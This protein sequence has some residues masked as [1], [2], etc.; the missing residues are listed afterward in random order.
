MV[1]KRDEKGRFIKGS[2]ANPKGRPPRATEKE[3][4]DTVYDEIPI[5]RFRRMIARQ[6]ERAERGDLKAL[7][8]LVRIIGLEAARKIDIRTDVITVEL[9]GEAEE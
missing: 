6:A 4:L 9:F 5:E 2:V 7:E 8:F 1:V 3:Y